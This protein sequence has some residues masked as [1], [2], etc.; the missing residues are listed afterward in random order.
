[1]NKHYLSEEITGTGGTIKES[2]EDFRV[3]EIPLYTP[4]GEGEHLYI[5]FEKKGMTTHQLL[6]R[7]AQ[8]FSVAER[9]IGYA[10]LKDAKATTTQ[11]ISVPLIE[12][13]AAIQLEDDQIR[14]LSAVKHRNKLRLGHLAGNRFLIRIADPLPESLSRAE[15]VFEVLRQQG[16]PNYFGAQRYGALGNSHL[17]GRAIL[18]NDFENGCHLMMGDPEKIEHPDWKK[19][20]ELYRTNELDSALELLPRHCRYERILLAS[21]AKGRT[22]RKS[23]LNLPR[24]ILRLYL[25]AYQSSLFDRIVDMRLKTIDKLWPGDLAIKH[26]NG[27]CFQVEDEAVEQAR[28]DQFEISATGPLFGHKSMLAKGQSGIIEEA[29]LD[30]EKLTLTDFKLGKGLAMSGERRPLRVPLTEADARI[31]DDD[32]M[33]SFALPKG[34][35]ATSLLREV[36]KGD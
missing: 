11:T 12:P 34:S 14:I 4:C 9:D 1:M 19:A 7:A 35:Y 36:I 33:L 18:Q 8:V 2:P 23:L 31:E 22:H 32:L 15:K 10:G 17:I 26:I 30:N 21:L 24:N 3:E 29:L 28:A 13:E 20:V 16:V 25:S 6:R 27:A 5:E